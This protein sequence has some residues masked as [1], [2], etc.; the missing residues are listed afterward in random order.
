MTGTSGVVKSRTSVSK[1]ASSQSSQPSPTSHVST[2]EKQAV[3]AINVIPASQQ[4]CPSP[5]SQLPTSRTESTSIANIMPEHPLPGITTS[6]R[7]LD[8]CPCNQSLK[9]WKIDCS[10]C[11]QFWHV[12]CLKMDGLTEKAYNKMVHYLCPFC[13]V[14]PVPTI[15]SDVDVCHSCRNTLT[16]QQANS[17]QE[18]FLAANKMESLETFCKSV[19]SIDFESLSDQLNTVQALDVHLKHFL[20]KED[21]L[22]EHQDHVKGMDSSVA[23]LSEQIKILQSHVSELN[24][25]SNS[26]SNADGVVSA[27]KTEGFLEYITAKL[28]QLVE[29]EPII[30]A[31][32]AEMQQS[33]NK[34]QSTFT[35]DVPTPVHPNSE[36]PSPLTTHHHLSTKQYEHNEHPT[37]VSLENF[38]DEETEQTL[39][40]M[41]ETSTKFKNENGHSVL[42]FGEPYSYSGSQAEHEPIPEIIAAIISR[43]NNDHNCVEQQAINSCLVNRY[44]G[45]TSFLPQ[46]SDDEATIHPESTIF[47]LSIGQTCQIK[48]C[49][50]STGNESDLTCSPQSIYG[51][52][53]K[54]Q[55]YF[56]HKINPGAIAEG[57]RYSLTM[58]SV[59]HSN[60]N[61]TCI[62]GDSNTGGLKFGTDGKRTFG[63][64]LP[65][66]QFYA[67]TIDDINPYVS[68]GYNNV[69]I[70]CGINDIRK[71]NVK[72]QRELHDIYDFLVNKINLIQKSNPKANIFVCPV[73]PTKSELYNKKAL[74]FI[75]LIRT[76]LLNSNFGI[77]FVD[78]FDSFL[79]SNGFLCQNLSKEFDRHQRRDYLHL[80]WRGVA[81]LGRLIRNTVLLRAHGGVDKRKRGPNRVDG[82]TYRDVA[83]PVE[84]H[85]SGQRPV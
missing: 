54:S 36:R 15:Q 67:P 66:K 9:S 70:M 17:R 23:D 46:H 58:R 7:P 83:A 10:K 57:V 19:S 14:P 82:R 80:N 4:Q 51:M 39:L 1:R 26:Q 2:N 16:L 40:T 53:R 35:T 64:A 56:Q 44:N 30:S 77:T 13:F 76:G 71:S 45:P 47:T 63:K 25:N 68:C 62:I 75:N 3:P 85:S 72:T 55:E 37:S 27:A 59:S 38:I 73:L 48:F 31:S 21:A 6:H 42:S 69:V 32:I 34:A 20:L 81:Q 61:S 18:V 52:S 49:E 60:R 33:L 29:K 41:L 43:I 50:K 11:H 8:K 22:K 74:Y 84:E 78:G 28:D 79:D 24:Q 12:E 65:G 5:R